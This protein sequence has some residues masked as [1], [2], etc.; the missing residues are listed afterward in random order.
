[1]IDKNA[2]MRKA[3]ERLRW[4]ESSHPC[5]DHNEGIWSYTMLLKLIAA[6]NFERYFAEAGCWQTLNPADVIDGKEDL[7]L[8]GLSDFEKDCLQALNDEV[9]RRE[10]ADAVIRRPA[11]VHHLDSRRR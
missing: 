11:S 10:R 4:I 2:V 1:M 3:A 9:S 7:G 6:G 5:S 8:G